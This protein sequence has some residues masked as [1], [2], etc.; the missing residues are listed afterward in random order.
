[1]PCPPGRNGRPL[2]RPGPARTRC[3]VQGARCKYE[4]RSC[5]VRFHHFLEPQR[6]GVPIDR[7]RAEPERVVS[8]ASVHGC[9]TLHEPGSYVGRT[10]PPLADNTNPVR[11][12]AELGGRPAPP[13]SIAHYLGVRYDTS[14]G[15]PASAPMSLSRTAEWLAW[16][17]PSRCAGHGLRRPPRLRIHVE[18]HADVPATVGPWALN[19][20]V[21]A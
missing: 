7:A 13:R 8:A 18:V 12:W 2:V 20:V 21:D 1:M 6:G 15:P 4:P 17:H 11:I 9:R 5:Y 14:T 16:F 3:K 10:T 19:L